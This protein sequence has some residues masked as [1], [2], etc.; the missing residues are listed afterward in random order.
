MATADNPT[1]VMNEAQRT[2]AAQ[3]EANSKPTELLSVF[4]ATLPSI[5][6]IFPNGRPAIFVNNRFVTNVPY[7]INQLKDE[8]VN[9]HPHIYQKKGEETMSAKNLDPMEA[10]REKIIAEAVASGLLVH[11]NPNR[12]MGESDPG[13]LKPASTTDVASAAAGGSGVQMVS[14][15]SGTGSISAR[16]LSLSQNTE[17][18]VVGV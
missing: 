7:E 1:A 18:P 2:I 4:W 14:D 3:R 5:N 17:S 10:I 8:I 11:G 9:G 6:Y 16:L 12:D 13:K 15:S